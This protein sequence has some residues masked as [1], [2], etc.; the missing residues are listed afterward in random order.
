MIRRYVPALL[1][2]VLVV[3]GVAL[4]AAR[5]S[6]LGAPAG[7]TSTDAERLG[8]EP[9]QQVAAYLAT[10]PGRLPAPG[11]AAVPA[12]V[13]LTLGM[14]AVAVA[15]LPLTGAPVKAV[16]RVPLTRVQT[17]MRFEP[18]SP[19]DQPDPV[20]ARVRQLTLARAAAQREAADDAYRL[21]GRPARV[22]AAEAAALA[23]SDCR[24]VLALLVQGDRSALDALVRAP[25]VRAVDAAPRGTPVDGVALS[26]LLPEQTVTAGPVP[27]DGPPPG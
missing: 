20:A 18:L 4:V 13:Q 5:Q 24:C 25:G 22:A 8:P 7:R 17:A 11:A 1:V 21:A 16:F 14:D 23:S 19:V 10:L 12:L 3:A 2:C 9:G 15:H 26:P 6:M 27:D